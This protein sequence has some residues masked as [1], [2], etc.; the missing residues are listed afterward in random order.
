MSES[1]HQIMARLEQLSSDIHAEREPQLLRGTIKNLRKTRTTHDFMFTQADRNRMGAASVAA[2][3]EGLGGLAIG[4]AGSAMDITDEAD[5]LEFELDGKP[6]RAWVWWSVFQDGDDVEIV[7]EPMGDIWQAY[8]IR[9]LTDKMLALHP[10]CS[11]GRY[12]HYKTTLYWLIKTYTPLFSISFLIS[13]YFILEKNN[14]INYYDLISFYTP[15][16]LLSFSFSG[17][18]AWRIARKYKGFVEL[19]ERIFTV[20]GWKDVKNIDLP[21]ITKKNKRPGDPAALGTLFFRY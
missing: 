20:F 1:T 12:A 16:F 2:A 11:R 21:A 9:R 7:A 3:M 14:H 19:A 5:L 13:F 17:I 8:G 10:H 6:I 4:L 15:A 18:I